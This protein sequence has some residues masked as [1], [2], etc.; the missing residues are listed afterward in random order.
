MSVDFEIPSILR[1]PEAPDLVR[2][3]PATN[4]SA[5]PISLLDKD[6]LRNFDLFDRA[7]GS[8]PLLTREQNVQ[9]SLAALR[10]IAYGALTKSRLPSS[11]EALPAIM[12]DLDLV[13]SGEPRQA[14]E[15]RNRLLNQ[16]A[17]TTKAEREV[18]NAL[19][20][21]WAFREL[22]RSLASAFVLLVPFESID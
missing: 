19:A 18:V 8:L 20:R 17:T 12:R 22:S 1:V 9:A 2:V 15:A 4:L 10:T 11:L 3:D 13:V 14:S 6:L 5:V 21:D 16:G 7:G